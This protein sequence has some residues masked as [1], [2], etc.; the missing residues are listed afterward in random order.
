M[1]VLIGYDGSESADAALD[2]LQKAGLPCELEALTVSVGEVV[3]PPYLVGSQMA[4]MPVTPQG[5]K[6]ALAQADEQTAQSLKEAERFWLGTFSTE[7]VTR[8]HCSVEVVRS[9]TN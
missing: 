9:A 1:R 7:L 3:M 5:I 6:I 8:A 2:D 4:G